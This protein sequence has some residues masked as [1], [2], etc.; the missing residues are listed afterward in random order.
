MDQDPMCIFGITSEL[1]SLHDPLEILLV[2]PLPALSFSF[3][4]QIVVISGAGHA[5]KTA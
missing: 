4:A 5:D 3:C 2:L 1:I